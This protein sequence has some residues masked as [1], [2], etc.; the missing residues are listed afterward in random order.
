MRTLRPNRFMK[1]R[2]S[3]LRRL[4]PSGSRKTHGLTRLRLSTSEAVDL[5]SP[6]QDVPSLLR[7]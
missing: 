4:R 2:P 6:T 3:V 5:E 7:G 1:N